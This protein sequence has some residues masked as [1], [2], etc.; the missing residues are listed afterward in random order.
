MAER[1]TCN[2]P[3]EIE[4]AASVPRKSGIGHPMA[5]VPMLRRNVKLEIPETAICEALACQLHIP[6]NFTFG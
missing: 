4:I 2:K 1:E 5:A 3:G 6:N